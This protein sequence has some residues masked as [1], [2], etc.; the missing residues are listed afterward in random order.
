MAKYGNFINGELFGRPTDV[1]WCMIFPQGGTACRHP[2][3][4]YE[5]F[6]EGLILFLCM[7]SLGHR[8]RPPGMVFWAFVGL[9]G[10]FR[11][12]VEFTRQPDPQLGFILGPLSM[13][14]LLSLPMA[15][16]GIYLGGVL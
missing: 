14:Q 13:G 2:S 4:L 15:L 10:V 12:L 11:F 8:P 16:L 7:W 5:A 9:Y 1:P 3:Q 6:L